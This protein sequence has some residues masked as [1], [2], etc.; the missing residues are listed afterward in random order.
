MGRSK[1]YSNQENQ[2]GRNK[3]TRQEKVQQG[4]Q[5]IIKDKFINERQPEPIVAK[6]DKQKEYL[7][8]LNDPN[9][10]VICC[11][12]LH[13]VG[14][15]FLPSCVAADKYRKGEI[16]KIIV[17]RP[18]VQTGKSSGAKPG[19]SLEKLYPYVRNVLDTIKGR[20]GSGAFEIALQD[21]LKG[22]IEA[23]E[24]ESIRG[25]SFDIPS[26]LIVDECQQATPEEVLAIITRI[27]DNCKLVLCGDIN[28]RDIKG[29]SGLQ[30]F[31]DLA[32]RHNLK[33]VG[34]INFDSPEDIVRGGF[35]KDIAIALMKDGKLKTSGN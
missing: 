31:L 30:W 25:R 13:G 18:Y 4:T 3:M 19:T 14:K 32:K 2:R 34:L 8:M 7:K 16:K 24:L 35:V 26:F 21:G 1:S 27:S 10:Q 12:G 20:I 9:I 11:L 17:A 23:Q 33:G 6:T 5:K 28:Q 22:D 15:T 29:E